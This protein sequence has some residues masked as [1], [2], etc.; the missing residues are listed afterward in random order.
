MTA[1]K[2]P[3]AHAPARTRSLTT[4][5][6]VAA[7]VA[8]TSWITVTAG[9]V[10]FTLQTTFVLLAALLLTPGWAAASMC[11]YL[12]LGAAGLPVFSHGQAGLGALL[13]PTGGF[14]VGFPVA[15]ALA[16]AAYRALARA[17][18]S[19]GL[20]LG[21]ALAAVVV[22]ELALYAVGLPW[23]AHQ[24]GI[25]LAKAAA[26]ACVPFL[27]PDALK[28]SVAVAAAGALERALPPR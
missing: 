6:V 10:P 8:G 16:S 1:E 20:R 22:G 3:A 12:V 14:L 26:V 24:A 28:A 9:P 5:A 18:A 7:L 17:S 4:A 23:L 19:R 27:V 25:S 13:G 2:H 11:V 15:A 21:A